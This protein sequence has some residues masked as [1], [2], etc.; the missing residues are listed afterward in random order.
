M[1]TNIVEGIR[2]E[3]E[4]CVVVGV[5]YNSLISMATP[6]NGQNDKLRKG[7]QRMLKFNSTTKKKPIRFLIHSIKFALIHSHHRLETQSELALKL[8]QPTSSFC[9]SRFAIQ[10]VRRIKLVYCLRVLFC[11]FGTT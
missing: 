6:I 9:L 8:N 11:V 7:D 3:Q 10:L 2:A 4:G 1:E 5:S